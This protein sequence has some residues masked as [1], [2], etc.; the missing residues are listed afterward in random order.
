MK[1][2]SYTELVTAIQDYTKKSSFTSTLVDYLITEAEAEMNARLRTRRQLTAL[3]PTVS[4]AG[5]VTIPNDFGGWKRFTT[6]DASQAWDLRLLSAEQEYDILSAYTAA[7]RPSALIQKGT[8]AQVW[9]YTDGLY[10]FAALYYA[11]VPNLTSTAT[12]NWVILNHPMAYLYGCLAAAKGFIMD[13][14]RIAMWSSMF[15]RALDRIEREDALDT[16]AS[17]DS[18]LS[19]NTA[20]FRTGSGYNVLSDC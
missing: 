9:P 11:R 8:T 15:T 3:T 4:S 16:S 2:A 1:P 20:L 19:V 7:S 18:T 12:T 17:D 14:E 10:T 5:V 13:D 6:R